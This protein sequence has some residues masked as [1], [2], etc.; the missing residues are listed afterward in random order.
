MAPPALWSS[1]DKL[2]VGLVAT[3]S[4]SLLSRS[5][6]GAAA[7]FGRPRPIVGGMEERVRGEVVRGLM[8]GG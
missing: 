6:A 7:S 5:P 8:K 3:P 2:V 4:F 1:G